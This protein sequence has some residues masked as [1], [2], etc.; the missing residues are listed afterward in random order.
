MERDSD[1]DLPSSKAFERESHLWHLPF[2]AS[3][4]VAQ[5]PNTLI[6][7]AA[8]QH[9][10]AVVSDAHKLENRTRFPAPSE[11]LLANR[12]LACKKLTDIIRSIGLVKKWIEGHES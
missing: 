5:R 11:H 4:G 12:R 9:A 2:V 8:R 10:A 1:F 3:Q 6:E 7:P